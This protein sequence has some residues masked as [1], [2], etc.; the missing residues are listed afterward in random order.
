[1]KQKKRGIL[2]CRKSRNEYMI[3]RMNKSNISFR[4]HN[5]IP[6][7]IFFVN[8]FQNKKKKR[9]EIW[10]SDSEKNLIEKSPKL[11]IENVNCLFK[12]SYTHTYNDQSI[13]FNWCS[14]KLKVLKKWKWQNW[15]DAEAPIV[16]GSGCGRSLV[17]LIYCKTRKSEVLTLK[18]FPTN[19]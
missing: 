6:S 8:I 13:T 14:S 16:I 1:M 3:F 5:L 11:E 4:K 7:I 17:L 2:H 18:Y 10:R 19:K 9:E 15:I 12:H